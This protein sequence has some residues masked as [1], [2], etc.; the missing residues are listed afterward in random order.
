MKID[1]HI[2]SR[3]SYDCCTELRDIVRV[4][5]AKGLDG[6]C[7]TEH[8]TYARSAPWRRAARVMD[9]FVV[10]TGAE[11]STDIGHLLIFGL[12][13]DSWNTW[14]GRT[15]LKA[16]DVARWV[17][18]R[19]GAVVAAHP[20][21]YDGRYG[22]ERIC[23]I[24]GITAI[25]TW[26]ARCTPEEVALAREEAARLG[27]PTTGGSDAHVGHAAGDAYTVFED[28]V[29]SEEAL[30]AALKSGRYRAGP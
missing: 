19:G 29:A 30:V 2:H 22:S 7:I 13:D 9:D 12:G 28:L 15:Y 25:E 27:L 16:E 3:F 8:H 5:R 11:A 18:N 17:N 23:R 21:R 14:D 6:V 26:N 4:A 1:L 10:L 24:P 20:F